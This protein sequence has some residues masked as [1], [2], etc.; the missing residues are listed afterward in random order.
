MV[1]SKCPEGPTFKFHLKWHHLHQVLSLNFLCDRPLSHVHMRTHTLH[2]SPHPSTGVGC[3]LEITNLTQKQTLLHI[4]LSIFQIVRNPQVIH[5]TNQTG[6][7]SV[8]VSESGRRLFLIFLNLPP[9]CHCSP[10]CW[11]VCLVWAPGWPSMGCGWS[12]P[13]SYQGSQRSGTCHRT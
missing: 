7:Y 5:S 9:S 6:S 10:T 1:S 2:T 3:V 4:K 13:S 11:H 12:S 8:C